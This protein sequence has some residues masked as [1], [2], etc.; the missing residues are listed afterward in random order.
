M[1]PLMPMHSQRSG[2]L[3]AMW[4]MGLRGVA[5][6]ATTFNNLSKKKGYRKNFFISCG[7]SGNKELSVMTLTRIDFLLGSRPPGLV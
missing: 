6:V 3:K 7:N 2:A 4:N 5:T 1:L